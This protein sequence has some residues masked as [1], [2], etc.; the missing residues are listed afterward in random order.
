MAK[1]ACAEAGPAGGLTAV[2]FLPSERFDSA[3][4][5]YARFRSGYPAD[6]VDFLAAR[7]RLTGRETVLDVGCGT[8]QLAIPLARHAGR[9][10]A[11]DPVER[12]LAHGRAA[13]GDAPVDWVL[14]DSG[15]LADLTVRSPWAA[16]FAAS[17]H[18]TDRPE[19]LRTL[20]D[21]LDPAG[22]VV[23]IGDGLAEDEQPDWV[24]AID[25]IRAAY[26]GERGRPGPA[27]HHPERTH[28]D[29]LRASPFGDVGEVSWSWRRELTV[30]QA[31]G[32]QFSYSFS[33]PA[34]LGERADAFAR[35]V[36]A[37]VLALHPGGTVTEP[38]RA[39]VLVARRPTTV[40]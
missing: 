38:H 1:P 10:I 30:E 17:F 37:A 3:T 4:E 33:T 36:R 27:V 18:W 16:T 6:L 31:I 13:A 20:A 22:V 19:V 23:V 5:H 34:L 39:R 11:I 28:L 25:E 2:T 24:R 14:G 15:T 8:G 21:L 40:R 26:L 9:V 32:L 12:M 35:D 7:L 29:V